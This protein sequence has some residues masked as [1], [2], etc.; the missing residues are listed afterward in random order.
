MSIRPAAGRGLFYTRDSAGHSEL[1]PPQYVA[2]ARREAV[3]LG[4]AFAGT[5]EAICAMVAQGRSAEG[6]LF[7][8]YGISGNRLSRPGFDAFRKAA[9]RDAQVSHLFVPRRDRI[10]RPDNP[11][12][13]I[14][15]ECD[16][17]SAGLTLVFMDRLVGPL[18][19]GQRNELAD[20]LTT[21]ID[22]DNSGKFRRELAEKL[23]HAKIKLAELGLS[24]GGE[25]PH[26]F[27]RWLVGPDREPR[28]ELLDGEVVKMAGHHVVWLPTAERDMEVNMR[29]LDLIE[30]NPASR[31]ARIFNDEGIP[32]P[33]AGRFRKV[34]NVEVANSGLWTQNTVKNIATHPLLIACWAYGRR[35]SGDQLRLTP[36]GPR[37]LNDGDYHPDGRLRAVVN[38]AAGVIRT[39]AD[40]KAIIPAERHDQI[41]QILEDRG[42][43]L[44][45]KA[46]TRGDSPNALGGRVFDLGCGW[47]M[48]RHARRGSWGY[49]CALYQNSQ[50][51]ACAHNVVDGERATRFVLACLRQ[52]VLAPSAMAKLR[53]ELERLAAQESGG[54]PAAA[55]LEARRAELAAVDKRLA[56]VGRNMALAETPEERSATAAVFADL[57][58]QA[59]RLRDELAAMQARPTGQDAGR[60]VAAALAGRDRL[61][62]FEDPAWGGSASI[63][64]LFR[65][66]DARLYLRFRA[67]PRGRATTQT[68][69]G[70]VLTFGSTPPPGPLYDGP[71]DRAIHRA[72]LTA[73]ESG[74][75]APGGV[76]PGPSMEPGQEVNWSANVQRG[77]SRCSGPRPRGR[78]S[79]VRTSPGCGRVCWALSLGGGSSPC[80][81]RE[82]RQRTPP[83]AT[84]E[85]D[86]PGSLLAG[87][88]RLP[89]AG[90][91]D[92]PTAARERGGEAAR[93]GAH[94]D[95]WPL[96]RG[97]SLHGANRPSLQVRP[98]NSTTSSIRLEGRRLTRPGVGRRQPA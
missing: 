49:Q 51:Q 32:S 57:T 61:R 37:S 2:W 22:Y 47:P 97:L 52:R 38:D 68:L 63:G 23:I 92:R 21:L 78:F 91:S 11:V 70:G 50:S 43:H 86:G 89:P 13:A 72:R 75:T 62:D 46:R 93:S 4:V 95:P 90:R 42:R 66:V 25:P 88:G 77:T 3:R 40:F 98:G 20:M 35:S 24:I 29:I 59:E 8:D 39:P 79:G 7:L 53:A 18:Q 82:L 34:G 80:E 30:T 73:G 65:R 33:K 69:D 45:G 67:E 41:C 60:E 64:E 6:D 36:S 44:K 31:I 17:R 84:P 85:S 87:R 26:G 55:R 5:P 15:I 83:N 81:S 14:T 10:A 58:A 96:L 48:Y 94:G 19:R 56:T 76:P 27:R 71:T 16:L 54:D 12:D 9:L 74:S 1:A 28:R